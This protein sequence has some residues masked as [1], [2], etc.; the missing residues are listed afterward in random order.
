MNNQLDILEQL[1]ERHLLDNDLYKFTMMWFVMNH[2]P[3]SKVRYEFIDRRGY[4]YPQGLGAILN[5]RINSFRDIKMTQTQRRAFQQKCPFLPNLFFDF[6]EGY[7]LDPSE[8]NIYQE[9]DGELRINIIGYQ[10]RTILWE[11][12]L[13]SEISEINFLMTGEKP[14]EA[15]QYLSTKNVK[16]GVKLHMKNINFVDFG[17]RRR[18]SFDNQDQVI[19]D[20]K[21]G[22]R[23]SFVGTSNVYFGIKHDVKII[24]TMAHEII[25]AVGAVK[26]YAHANKHL[27]EMWNQ[28][29]NGNLGSVLTDSFGLDSFLKDFDS[30]QS[31]IWDSVRHDSG[32]PKKFTDK[33]IEHYKK[34]GID[35][36]SKT[37]I[38]SDGLN[39]DKAIELADYCRG[40]IK[41]SFGIGTFF[42]NDVGV[43]PLNIVIKL[44]M[45]DDKHVIK[46]SDIDEKH[47]GNKRTIELVK[48]MIG[49][50]P[51]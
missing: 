20:L 45:I 41:T 35:P 10:Y 8:V 44:F 14:A 27:M 40:K 50:K 48:E 1:P 22:G 25:C 28:T 7:R 16:K 29:Y 3:E 4:K 51:L 9:N 42:S 33:I 2:F 47:T 17:T 34:I 38:F 18:Y 30:Y 26:G 32:D 19:A 37:I 15:Q 46:L 5:R 21:E 31:R 24:G 12:I 39:V 13:M 43:K 36:M 23:G 11:I 6:L 49:Y